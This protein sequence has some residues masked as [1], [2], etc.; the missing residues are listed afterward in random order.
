MSYSL[1]SLLRGGIQARAD[2]FIFQRGDQIGS[3]RD[4]VIQIFLTFPGP[5][6]QNTGFAFC[7]RND[8]G[9]QGTHPKILQ[10]GIFAHAGEILQSQLVFDDIVLGFNRLT[11]K[12][13]RHMA[14]TDK[15]V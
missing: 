1:V 6:N 13:K 5:I 11:H 2:K 10:N 7:R 8:I 14:A 9:K 4:I 3:V 12:V 15:T